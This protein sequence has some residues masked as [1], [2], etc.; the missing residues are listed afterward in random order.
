M[1][2]SGFRNGSSPPSAGFCLLCS[3]WPCRAPWAGAKISGKEVLTLRSLKVGEVMTRQVDVVHQGQTVAE[4]I[5]RLQATNHTGFPVLDDQ[6]RLVGMVTL[7]DI[8][9]TPLKGRL[10]RRV[11]QVMTA[12]VHAV[13]PDADLDRVLRMFSDHNIG[14]VPVIEAVSGDR[15]VGIVTRSDVLGAYNTRL[16][17]NETEA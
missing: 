9:R 16:L 12:P 7:S 10:E 2:R 3:A 11:E 8:R 17:Q 13:V 5:Q 4:V 6:Q 14:R 1:I 15:L